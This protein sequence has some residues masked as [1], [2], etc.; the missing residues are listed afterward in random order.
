MGGGAR[1]ACAG[2]G[3]VHAL[4]VRG[5]S[6]AWGVPYGSAMDSRYKRH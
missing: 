5:G 4:S 3:T 2:R 1:Q 6:L